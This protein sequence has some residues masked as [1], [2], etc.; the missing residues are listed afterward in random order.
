METAQAINTCRRP[1]SVSSRS[2]RRRFGLIGNEALGREHRLRNGG[3]VLQRGARDLRRSTTPK[4][5]I[6]PYSPVAA[7][8]AIADLALTDMPRGSQSPST[9]AFAAIWRSGASRALSTMATPVLSSPSVLP[10]SSSTAGIAST[11]AVPP[12]ATM[13]S[14]TAAFVEFKASSM[15][16][17]FSFISTSVAAPTLMTS[18]AAGELCEALLELLAVEVRRSVLRD[19]RTDLGNTRLDGVLVAGAVDDNRVL[20]VNLD[21]ACT[22]EHRQLDILEFDAEVGGN[23]GAAGQRRDILQHF[24]AAVAEARRLDRAEVQRTAQLVEQQV[25]QRVRPRRRRAIKRNFLPVLT[26]FSSSG[27]DFLERGD[28]HYP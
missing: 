14:S 13:P 1:C 27:R 25:R 12:P 7:L 2:R 16:I 19:L 9:P 15:R 20:L 26:T 4:E 3:S 22:A 23:H 8:L 24:L 5:S 18:H 21:L 11:N 28:L 17:F 10:S 6:S